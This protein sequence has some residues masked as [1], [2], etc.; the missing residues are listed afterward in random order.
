MDK[1]KE[2]QKSIYLCFIDYL[3]PLAVWITTNCGK[4]LNTWE[5]QGH[6]TCLLRNLYAGHKQQ[7]EVDM[8]QLIC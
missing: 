2:F 6:L 5:Y 1:V 3:K 8:E 4:F 7:L